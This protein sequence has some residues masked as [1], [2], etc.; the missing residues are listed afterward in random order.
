MKTISFMLAL[1]GLA[2]ATALV[3]WLGAGAV[4]DTTRAVGWGGFFL[5]CALQVR[6]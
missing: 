3:A 6:G 4:W 5:L 1:L 2:A